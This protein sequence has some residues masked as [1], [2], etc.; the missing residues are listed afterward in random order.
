MIE[1]AADTWR[2]WVR[3]GLLQP[4]TYDED[5]SEHVRQK[6]R[7]S[8]G[9]DPAAA[10]DVAGWTPRD[11]MRVL[12]P[13]V[14]SFAG[15]ERDI[16]RLLERI[17]ANTGARDNLR[18]SYEFDEN[19]FLDQSLEHFRETVLV[20]E[21]VVIQIISV[22]FPA[23]HMWSSPMSR[24]RSSGRRSS[25]VG[26]A[27][28][29]I[30][31]WP[32][33]SSLPAP[34]RTGNER[35]D[36]LLARY[37]DLIDAVRCVLTTI[38]DTDRE[39]SDW[40]WKSPRAPDP[41][42]HVA[43]LASDHW[44][45][46]E[47]DALLNFA[48]AV[49]S[50]KHQPDEPFLH[51]VESWLDEIS[52]GAATLNQTQLSR[53]F[54]DVLSLPMWGKRHEL[55]SVWIL[56]QMD[57]AL[58]RER[59]TFIVTNGALKLPFKRTLVATMPSADGTI[60]L[61]SEL[62]SDATGLLGKGRTKAIQPDYRFVLAGEA[63]AL[64]VEVKQY[65]TAASSKHADVL[66]DYVTNTVAHVVLVGHGPLGD[67]LQRKIP[68]PQQ[69]RAHVFEDVRTGQPGNSRAF[70]NTIT[71]HLPPRPA[72]TS[73]RQVSLSW[74]EEV[75]DLDL[76]IRHRQGE[77][78]YRC[79]TSEHINLVSDAVNGGPEVVNVTPDGTPFEVHVHV[80][81]GADIISASPKV[82]I[83][84]TGGTGSVVTPAANVL[85]RSKYWYVGNVDAHGAWTPS[86]QS[87]SASTSAIWTEI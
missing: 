68:S 81:D 63:D 72:A 16:L 85:G 27:D 48:D 36:A 5:V 58:S 33:S 66:H 40:L 7:V 21:S 46:F 59:M 73:V 87:V 52:I 79:P 24:F 10:M 76:H 8:A 54:E 9:E 14:S 64:V 38:G 23:G 34:A 28:G 19:D 45:S 50:G 83:A 77:V 42:D 65:R 4:D 75:P 53:Q 57:Q 35:V 2:R 11:L 70:R 3:D 78:S 80:Y 29:A 31:E 69:H 6:L 13:H 12:A 25:A 84:R 41:R 1:T 20:A 71:G 26:A 22:A 86:A 67:D 15:M 47:V 17:G 55:Y 51:E 18:L 37:V 39:V 49:G 60:E 62:R 32:Y 61:W 82:T 74:N 44:I 43:E 30:G 56:S